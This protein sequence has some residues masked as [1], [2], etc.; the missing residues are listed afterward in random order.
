MGNIIAIV[1]SVALAILGF[2]YSKL[3]RESRKKDSLLSTLSKFA[4]EKLSETTSNILE[5]KIESVTKPI[6]ADIDSLNKAERLIDEVI[7]DTEVDVK[8]KLPADILEIA[9]KSAERMK[10]E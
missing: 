4:T 6:K 2:L 8:S 10:S 3:K 9:R 1:A 7:Q 5:E